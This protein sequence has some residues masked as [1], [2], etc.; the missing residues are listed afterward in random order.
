[1]A[2]SSRRSLALIAGLYLRDQSVPTAKGVDVS[3]QI[4]RAIACDMAHFQV[5]NG[6]YFLQ[7]ATERF[8]SLLRDFHWIGISTYAEN[9]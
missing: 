7:D 5:L 1:M 6:W 2:G 9:G 4:D 3:E 8:G